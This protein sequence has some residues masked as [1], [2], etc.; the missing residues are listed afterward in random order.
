[1]ADRTVAVVGAGGF[2]GNR[3]VEML[4][5]TG[6]YEVRPVVRRASSLALARRFDIDGRIADALDVEAMRVALSGC[7]VVIHAVAGDNATI[8]GSAE[9][10]HEA[11]LG[12]GGR[13]FIY[14]SSAMVHGQS[15]PPG[16]NETAPLSQRQPIA[17]NN[18]KV[19]AEKRLRVLNRNSGMELA[20]LRPGIVYGPRSQWIGGLADSM[21]AGHACLVEGGLGLCNAVYVDNLVEAV[22]HCFDAP[23]AVNEAF[24][25]GEPEVPTWIEF[26]GRIAAA[27]NIEVSAIP[28]VSF[29]PQRPSLKDKVDGLRRT[30][31]VRAI[32]R[33]F[34]RRLQRGLAA[35]WQAAGAMPSEHAP[36]AAA[37]LE[38]AMLHR[39]RHVPSWEKVRRLLGYEPSVPVEEAWQRT[40]AWMRFAGYPVTG[41]GDG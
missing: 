27:L 34:P 19:L 10:V 24:L 15:P 16:C 6:E 37:T 23:E 14:L 1:M 28:S 2:I 40:I 22:M 5:L 8:V 32:L 20:I 29:V 26:Y 17:Y 9:A 7:D 41:D 25:I 38:F 4:H 31:P 21:L 11:V 33:S 13:R 3:I 36:G 30:R 18:A 12:A 39:A 35:F